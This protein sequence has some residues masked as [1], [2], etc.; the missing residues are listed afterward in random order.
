MAKEIDLTQL[1]PWWQ[2]AATFGKT[3]KSWFKVKHGS[4]AYND[5]DKY[6]RE[7]GWAPQFFRQLQPNQ[8]CTMPC[9]RPEWMIT[10]VEP[11]TR[12]SYER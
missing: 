9:E 6:F 7:L 5:W 8:E 12:L 2:E 3:N 1:H 10:A 4:P 11:K